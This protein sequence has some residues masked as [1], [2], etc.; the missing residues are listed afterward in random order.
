MRKMGVQS[1]S[2]L[3]LLYDSGASKTFCTLSLAKAVAEDLREI[4]HPFFACSI[5]GKIKIQFAAKLKIKITN[6]Y[7][8]L[9]LCTT[10]NQPNGSQ[11]RVRSTKGGLQIL[12]IG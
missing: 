5:A 4:E 3:Q 6:K 11:G 10:G 8:S 12:Q 2:S 9:V 7:E 1:P